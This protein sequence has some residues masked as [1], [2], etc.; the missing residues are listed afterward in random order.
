M[1]DFITDPALIN[2]ELAKLKRRAPQITD[3]G[4]LRRVLKHFPPKTRRTVFDEI[5]PLLGYDAVYPQ[6]N[7]KF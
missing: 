5:Q 4:R 2:A 1:H 7:P 6:G 3:A